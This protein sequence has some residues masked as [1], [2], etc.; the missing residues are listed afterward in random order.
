MPFLSMYKCTASRP[1]HPVASQ[2]NSL[3]GMMSRLLKPLAKATTALQI[4]SPRAEPGDVFLRSRAVRPTLQRESQPSA[5]LTFSY[6]PRTPHGCDASCSHDLICDLAN[7]R[8]LQWANPFPS[9]LEGYSSLRS[10]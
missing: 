3:A 2:L 8:H 1:M 5:L 9:L 10:Q 4:H 7:Q 6:N